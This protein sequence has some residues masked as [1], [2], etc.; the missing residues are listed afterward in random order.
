MA[1]YYDRDRNP[2]GAGTR[3]VAGTM[4]HPITHHGNTAEYMG[5]GFP[6]VKTINLDGTTAEWIE[7]P[8]VTQWLQVR[9]N[10]VSK[11]LYIAFSQS[12]M[13][14]GDNSSTSD[15]APSNFIE[16]HAPDHGSGANTLPPSTPVYRL[17]CAK[18]YLKASGTCSVSV[19]A[20]MTNVPSSQFPDISALPGVYDAP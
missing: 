16:L 11:V 17:K 6:Y 3:T 12:G 13:W 14:D 15:P 10:D 7:F 5:S 20:G 19:I 4:N 9:L 1:G 8:F 2:G 18:V